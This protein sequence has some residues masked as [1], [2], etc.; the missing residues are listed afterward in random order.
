MSRVNKKRVGENGRKRHVKIS[1]V[2]KSTL[3]EKNSR[4][5]HFSVPFPY[6]RILEE[7]FFFFSNV[8]C[9]KAKSAI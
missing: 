3:A 7:M 1:K 5:E 9:T 6:K 8:L 2:L 4:S